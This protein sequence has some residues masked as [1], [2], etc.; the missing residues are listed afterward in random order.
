[1]AF[2]VCRPAPWLPCQQWPR[3]AGIRRARHAGCVPPLAWGEQGGVGGRQTRLCRGRA[4]MHSPR[5]CVARVMW[6]VL[7]AVASPAAQGVTGGEFGEPCDVNSCN[8]G[9]FS[10]AALRG[11]VFTTPPN[12]AGY[13]YKYSM[14]APIGRN[15]L[16]SGCQDYPAGSTA[17]Q[18]KES[19]PDQCIQVRG[20][21]AAPN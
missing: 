4:A 20:A 2:V 5:H 1:V 8:C 19:D 14:C 3:A 11:K 15:Q 9:G 16:P 18:Y 6:V 10:F 17:I 12:A 21:A 7:A 13:S